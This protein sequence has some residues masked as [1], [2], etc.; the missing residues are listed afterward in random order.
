MATT[1]PPMAAPTALRSP[2][3]RP[4]TSDPTTRPTTTTPASGMMAGVMIAP[5]A[6]ATPIPRA[7]AGGLVTE[8][9][10][11]SAS[12]GRSVRPNGA[13]AMDRPSPSSTQGTTA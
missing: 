1:M 4:A 13:S 3:V 12:S 2:V 6:R 7:R 10:T 5:R 8:S 11:T 9:I